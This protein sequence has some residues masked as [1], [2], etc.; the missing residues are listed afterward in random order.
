MDTDIDS[1]D[2]GMYSYKDYE[3]ED[4]ED[5]SIDDDDDDDDDD[6][7]NVDESSLTDDES[8]IRSI[9]RQQPNVITRS[10]AKNDPSV[11]TMDARESSS[12]RVASSI[13]QS[14]VF[15]CQSRTVKPPMSYAALIAQAINAAPHRKL[16]LN[17]IYNYITNEY[18]Y[19]RIA[20][21]GWQVCENLAISF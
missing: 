8:R 10:K 2:N 13:D 6:D 19:Y 14:E 9:R 12:G 5:A 11:A 4:T 1:T 17:G 21:N 3:C 18:P 15:K 20:Q 7:M 16:T